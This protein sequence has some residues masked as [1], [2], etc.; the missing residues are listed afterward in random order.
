MAARV[1]VDRAKCQ[2]L[3]EACQRG[4]LNCVAALLREHRSGSGAAHSMQLDLNWR[5]DAWP[6]GAQPLAVAASLGHLPVVREL[7]AAGALPNVEVEARGPRARRACALERSGYT[8]TPENETRRRCAAAI[9]KICDPPSIRT[10]R[11]SLGCTGLE[12]TMFHQYADLLQGGIEWQLRSQ[13]GGSFTGTPVMDAKVFARHIHAATD[14]CTSSRIWTSY[15]GGPCLRP[16]KKYALRCRLLATRRALDNMVPYRTAWSA[17]T[18]DRPIIMPFSTLSAAL[19]SASKR[20]GTQNT[21]GHQVAF[22][23]GKGVDEMAQL[24][25][26][27]R[28]ALFDMATGPA[29]ELGLAR[30]IAG[31]SQFD[32]HERRT[33]VYVLRQ[34]R[35][36]WLRGD[37]PDADPDDYDPTLRPAW[38][39]EKAAVQRC[40]SGGLATKDDDGPAAEDLEIDPLFVFLR[41]INLE[42]Y[43]SWLYRIV[44]NLEQLLHAYRTKTEFLEDIKE[45][46][47]GMKPSHR[48]EIWL[49]IKKASRTSQST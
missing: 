33:L 22:D 38:L 13:K 37:D 28:K 3:W 41:N 32:Y 49:A 23:F 20:A 2:A 30:R 44:D 42:Q 17:W 26:V 25:I 29:L 14:P 43:T 11:V 12:A 4:D 45:S 19:D 27:D 48:R 6:S 1:G 16:G 24:G 7:L 35:K 8:R 10:T 18:H 5:S 47:P 36:E 21:D 31:G 39:M 9:A 34:Q 15:I 46:L 40:A